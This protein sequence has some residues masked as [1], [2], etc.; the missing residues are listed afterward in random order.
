MMIRMTGNIWLIRIQPSAEPGAT[1]AAQP[2]ERVRRGQGDE[3][4]MTRWRRRR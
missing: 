3:P 1:G 4:V 2:G